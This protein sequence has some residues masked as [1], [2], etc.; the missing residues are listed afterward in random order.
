MAC[1]WR[2]DMTVNQYFGSRLISE[3]FLHSACLCYIVLP[4][5]HGSPHAR[6]ILAAHVLGGIHFAIINN[7]HPRIFARFRLIQLSLFHGC[8]L[9]ICLFL[10]CCLRVALCLPFLQLYLSLCL[11]LPLRF[12]FL[13]H[14]LIQHSLPL[15]IL[16]FNLSE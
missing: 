3:C 10:P 6:H 7:S 2:N 15:F 5:Q 14:F 13:L 8:L 16:L 4:S 9:L 1:G 12:R 11:A